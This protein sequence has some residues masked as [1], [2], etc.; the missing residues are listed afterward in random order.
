MDPGLMEGFSVSH[1]NALAAVELLSA[2]DDLR[3]EVDACLKKVEASSDIDARLNRLERIA[4]E[5]LALVRE[6]SVLTTGGKIPKGV[7]LNEAKCYSY[8]CTA[9]ETCYA[10]CCPRGRGQPDEAGSM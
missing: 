1:A 10:P 2:F 8:V 3:G 4:E 5:T 7:P 9:G 6:T